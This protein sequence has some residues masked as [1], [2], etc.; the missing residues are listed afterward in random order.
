[1]RISLI[2]VGSKMPSWVS[3]G[4]LEYQK[5]LPESWSLKLV[6]IPL[7]KRNG[8]G[9]DLKARNKEAAKILEAV[10]QGAYVMC[11]DE[12]GKQYTSVELAS[13]LQEIALHYRDLALLVG[14]PE[15]HTDEVRARAHELWAL[16]RLTLPHPVVRIVLSE[17]LYRA[18]SI[19][20]NL[21]YHRA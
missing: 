6:E 19:A 20:A 3:E 1:M 17:A 7:I 21:P 15:G 13:H 10:P 9:E 12:R 18:Y 16:G 14:G 4:F 2:A 11:L 8:G 5:R